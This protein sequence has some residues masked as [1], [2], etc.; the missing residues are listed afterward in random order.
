MNTLI[1]YLR[2]KARAAKRKARTPA[3]TKPLAFA[4]DVKVSQQGH[5]YVAQH[6]SARYEAWVPYV[7]AFGSLV[8]LARRS[9]RPGGI[10]A[11][12][13]SVSFEL[14]PNYYSLPSLL[15]AVPALWQFLD[16]EPFDLVIG[17]LPEPLSVILLTRA[18][19]RRKRYVAIVVADVEILMKD[20]PIGGEIL[21]LCAGAYVRA[22]LRRSSGVIYV[23]ERTLQSKY[24]PPPSVPSIARSNVVMPPV[25][26]TNDLFGEKADGI[27]RVVS[28]G[29]MQTLA[30]GQDVLIQALTYLDPELP[31]KLTLVGGGKSE[32]RF[33]TL[34]DS[35]GL[36]GKVHMTGIIHEPS[37]IVK[38]LDASH[39]FVLASRSEGLPRA[40]IEAMARGLPVLGTP[41][42]GI[43]E[44]LALQDLVE[45]STPEEW[46]RRITEF[47]R[48]GPA[49][50][51]RSAER[52]LSKAQHITSQT[53]PERLAQF[54]RSIAHDSGQRNSPR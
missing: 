9:P 24:P 44:L 47:W 13:P 16:P 5:E 26:L 8:V 29:A 31:I 14:G 37:E 40:M 41:V 39:L 25:L 27:F 21:A 45:P 20:A 36:Q 6:T 4:T 28:I 35:L 51:R 38:I 22:L 10:Q 7:R 48:G 50:W 18:A 19:L 2:K 53:S 49:L 23:T 32:G 43:P 52:S 46:A 15:R 33:R 11:S 17:R 3:K 12:G 1:D 30:K 42:G 34:V 54:L